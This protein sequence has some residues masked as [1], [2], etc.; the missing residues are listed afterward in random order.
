MD[1]HRVDV[2]KVDHRRIQLQFAIRLS[3]WASPAQQGCGAP[4]AEHIAIDSLFPQL[5]SH[6]YRINKTKKRKV[7]FNIS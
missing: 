5:S 1:K 3:A 6:P 7:I 4:P 2:V